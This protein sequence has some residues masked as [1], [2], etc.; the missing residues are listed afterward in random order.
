MQ[1]YVNGEPSELPVGLTLRGLVQRLGLSPGQ[2]AV[3]RNLDIV[4]R[5]SYDQVVLTDGDR[6][7]IVTFVGGG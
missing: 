4:P 3:E 5:G 1:V 7:E 2:V 6:V